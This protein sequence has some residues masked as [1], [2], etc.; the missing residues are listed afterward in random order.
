MLLAA[1]SGILLQSR[2][3]APGPLARN[4]SL[5][6]PK[7]ESAHEIAA[8]LEREGVV[9]DRRLFIAGY[10]L[11]KISGWAEG[12]KGVQLK[13]GDYLIPQAASIRQVV[14]ILA[15]GRTV[16]YKVTIPEGL[17]SEQITERL[18]ADNNLA[19]DLTEVPP[20][21]SLLPETFI[22]QR[23]ASR[24]SIIDTMQPSRAS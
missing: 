4:K 15:E 22:V 24:Q 19:D 2:M 12:G 6:I 5:V 21:G 13:A 8:R 1:A 11:S 17:T 3:Q 7:G 10:L 23:G 18:K 16:S 9:A 14:D 20:E